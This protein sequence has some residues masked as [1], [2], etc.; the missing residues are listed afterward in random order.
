MVSTR[1]KNQNAHP[2]APLMT[3]AAKQKAGI[4]SK[5]RLKKVT[6]AQTIRELQARLSAL[7]NPG[8]ELFSKEPLVY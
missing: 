4:N 6:K 5:R 1:A 8:E 2:A 3:E 7:E